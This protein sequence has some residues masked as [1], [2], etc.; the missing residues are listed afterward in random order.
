MIIKKNILANIILFIH[1]YFKIK[2]KIIKKVLLLENSLYL[3]ISY[4]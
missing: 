4:F 1:I 2:T 3:K